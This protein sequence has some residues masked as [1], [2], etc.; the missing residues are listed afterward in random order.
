[1]H[2]SMDAAI[3]LTK[4]ATD[5]W[6]PSELSAGQA[7]EGWPRVFVISL[8][9]QHVRRTQMTQ[10]LASL[11][12]PFAFF[13]AVD[14]REIDASAH[15]IYDEVKRRRYFGRDLTGGEIGC[16]LSH[17]RVLQQIVAE[18]LDIAIVLEDDALMR[19]DFP[20]VVR[21]LESSDYPWELVRFLGS[22][23][24]SRLRQRN[25]ATLRSP[26]RL[27]RLS[28]TPGGAHAYLIRQSGAAK[29]LR[30]LDRCAYPIDT[31]MGRGWETGLE[32]LT[33]QP[34][35]AIT[36]PNLPS[37]IGDTRFCKRPTA[38]RGTRRLLFPFTRAWYRFSD[39][40]CKRWTYWTAWPR[41]CMSAKRL[42]SNRGIS[43]SG[44]IVRNRDI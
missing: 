44:S 43:T 33:V 19:A 5:S 13:D 4:S 35:L 9:D 8:P 23:K 26:Y 18:E 31:L 17:K 25:L 3:S 2:P 7:P 6:M 1:M 41:D 28:T 34:G 30:C 21:S 27:T 10:K 15:A 24:V 29:L 38:L 42:S 36:E 39:A 37:T 11:G 40:L 12:A 16:L 22:E 14:G 32:V 20:S